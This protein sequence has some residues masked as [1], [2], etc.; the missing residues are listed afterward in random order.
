MKKTLLSLLFVPFFGMAQN[1]YS[2]GFDSA[3]TAAGYQTTNQSANATT[4]LWNKASFTVPLAG[5][6]FGSGDVNTV[7]VGQAGG[8][9]SFAIVNFN[10]TT[11]ANTISNW[12]ISPDITVQNGDVVSFYTRKG[13][14]GT[15]D[16]P[17]RLE[18][19]MST[20]SPTVLPTGGP[21][22]LGSFTTLGTSVNPSL[23]AGFVYPKT[24]TQYTYTVSGLTGPTVVKFAFRYFVTNGGPS[25]NNSDIIGID[26]FSVDRALSTS[27]F[28]AKNFSVYP[29]PSNGLVN[30]S[31]KGDASIQN[32]QVTD[33]NGRVVK[34]LN[35][36]GVSET[37]VNISDLTT[38]VYFLKVQTEQG[39]GSTKIVKN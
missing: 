22:G 39:T 26:T 12:L 24:W 27:D 13:T 37:Q 31:S 9:N 33:L 28:F 17:D 11:G 15:Q 25:G 21:T 8:D 10:S 18:L 3:L 23:A 6:I 14:D 35:A 36:N 2:F 4:A 32:L 16:F 7:P 38:G 1:Q 30:V 5:A 20:A 19:R 29:N 34:T